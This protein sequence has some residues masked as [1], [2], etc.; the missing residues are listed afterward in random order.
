MTAAVVLLL[1]NGVIGA[2]DTLWYHEYKGRLAWRPDLYRAE[3]RLHASRDA[4]YAVLYGTIGWWRWSGLWAAVLLALLATEILVT[5]TD[6]VV[7]DR[8][9][10]LGAGERV[11]HSLMAIVYGAM[12]TQLLPE[13]LDRLR[14]PAALWVGD[15]GVPPEL[16]AMATLFGMGIA[17]SGI[18][19]A[20]ASSGSSKQPPAP[21]GE[22]P[23]P[24]PRSD[25]A[26]QRV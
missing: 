3:L 9:R 17:A 24:R 16:A 11:L 19:D 15:S 14:D 12:L 20:L 25:I 26:L 8:T 6:F 21:Q 1:V 22:R 7:E 10:P 4:V 18:R 23:E 5:L 13:L 2:V